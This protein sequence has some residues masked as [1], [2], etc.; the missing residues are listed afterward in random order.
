VT[1]EQTLSVQNETTKEALTV[2]L[3][4]DWTATD[5][6]PGDIINVI[7]TFT[8][9]ILTPPLTP[10]PSTSYVPPPDRPSVTITSKLNLL[11]L[12]PDLLVTAT[13]LSNA[14]QC[15]RKPILS[16]LVHSNAPSAYSDGSAMVWGNMLHAVLQESLKDD[17]WD[18]K[19]I[20]EKI[21]EKVVE[22]LEDLVRLGVSVQQAK[23]EVKKRAAGIKAFSEKYVG[24]TPKVST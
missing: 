16:S 20:E 2:I 14:N 24:Q 10:Q 18:D 8:R 1:F 17:K 13:A 3:R 23:N 11:I 12:C 9:P 19:S 6:R 22:G 21:D 15:L 5:V 7:G 4:D